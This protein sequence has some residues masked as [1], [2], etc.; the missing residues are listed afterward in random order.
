MDAAHPEF[1]QTICDNRTDITVPRFGFKMKCPLN[2]YTYMKH[3]GA[4]TYLTSSVLP[5]D[6]FTVIQLVS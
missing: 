3:P 4:G 2:L 6:Y 1:L 5:Y